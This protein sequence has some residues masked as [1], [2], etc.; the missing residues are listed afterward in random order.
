MR[1]VVVMTAILCSILSLTAAGVCVADPWYF[2]TLDSAVPDGYAYPCLA[3]DAGDYPHISLFDPD[4]YRMFYMAFDGIGWNGWR[5]PSALRAPGGR[6][7]A[8]DDTDYPHLGFRSLNSARGH[9]DLKYAAWN[10]TNW[11]TQIV[12]GVGDVAV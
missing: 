9:Y 1:R 12:D 8:L 7:M 2:H 5:A 4:G 6:F 3:L 11:D 10:G